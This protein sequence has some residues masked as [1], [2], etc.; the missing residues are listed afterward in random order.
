MCSYL[1]LGER[2]TST[3]L[4]AAIMATFNGDFFN[5]PFLDINARSKVNGIDMF[6]E[7]GFSK[8]T[9]DE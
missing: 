9:E 5:F 2:L 7:T 8:D 3:S 4:K 6:L 1:N